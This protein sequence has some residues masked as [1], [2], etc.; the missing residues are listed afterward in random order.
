MV[1]SEYPRIFE[2]VFLNTHALA[3]YAYVAHKPRSKYYVGFNMQIALCHRLMRS[4]IKSH[5]KIHT[6]SHTKSRRLN[7]KNYFSKLFFPKCLL[8]GSNSSHALESIVT[9]FMNNS[10][11]IHNQ[12]FHE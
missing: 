3:T 4:I 11:F 10:F 7:L 12:I 9:R 1:R 5:I 2:P 6:R 8:W